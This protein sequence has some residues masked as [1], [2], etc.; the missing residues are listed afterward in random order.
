M[1]SGKNSIHISIKPCASGSKTNLVEETWRLKQCREGG[2]VG[3]IASGSEAQPTGYRCRRH[4]TGQETRRHAAFVFGAVLIWTLFK[5]E[6]L[7]KTKQVLKSIK[8]WMV[9]W[10]RPSGYKCWNIFHDEYSHQINRKYPVSREKLSF[11][12]H[13]SWINVLVWHL[14]C[15]HLQ[16]KPFIS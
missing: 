15:I 3:R 9:K 11:Y 4:A 14:F 16:Q 7:E 10:W 6:A 13:F 5:N 8:W 1:I 2:G 12:R